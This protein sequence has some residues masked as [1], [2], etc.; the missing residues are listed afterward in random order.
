MNSKLMS[1]VAIFAIVAIIAIVVTLKQVGNNNASKVENLEA[2]I[3]L[4]IVIPEN[5]LNTDEK[6]ERT[7]KIVRIHNGVATILNGTFD[8]ETHEF[9][10]ERAI[11]I[12]LFHLYFLHTF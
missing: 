12:S 10:F 4:S 8:E 3:T 1:I 7:Y 5:L 9:T 6:V 2:P 11:K